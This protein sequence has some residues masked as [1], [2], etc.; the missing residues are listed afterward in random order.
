MKIYSYALTLWH[1]V[2]ERTTTEINGASRT[3]GQQRFDE[4]SMSN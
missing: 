1:N 4:I 3:T 2:L